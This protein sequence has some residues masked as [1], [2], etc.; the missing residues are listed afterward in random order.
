MPVL[1]RFLLANRCALS[2][3]VRGHASLE[4]A[5]MRDLSDFWGMQDRSRAVLA[6]HD[7]EKRESVFRKDH[8]QTKR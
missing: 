2:D 7:P 8:A 1:T 6:K 4:D 5:V 3:Q